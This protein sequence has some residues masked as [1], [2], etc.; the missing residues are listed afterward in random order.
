MIRPAYML[1]LLEK[2]DV[3]FFTGVPDSLLKHFCSEI[4]QNSSKRKHIIATN[5]GSA[6]GLATGHYIATKELALVY[7]QNSGLGNTINPLTS[8]CHPK[9][10]GIPMLLLI[11][12]RGEV[13]K[14]K[15][16]GGEDDEPQHRK[17]GEI[18]LKQL[19]LLDIPYIVLDKEEKGLEKKLAKLKNLSI[20]NSCPVA[21]V[22]RKNTFDISSIKIRKKNVDKRLLSRENILNIIVNSL[23]VNIP[24]ICTTGMA[25]RE[26]YEIRNSHKDNHDRDLLIIGG[27][28]HANQISAG[29][30]ISHP[31]K[32]IVCI[33]G[34]GSI[35]MHL[36]SLSITA[37][38]KN[39]IH[40]IINN[41]SHDS[42]GGQV[43]QMKN[44]NLTDIAKSLGYMHVEK[45]SNKK[46]IESKIKKF[47]SVKNKSIFLEIKSL[48]GSRKNLG[49]PDISPKKNKL[50][51]MKFLEKNGRF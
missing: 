32:K 25:S 1:A 13:N 28:G 20:K 30:A 47:L 43:T 7:M 39:I 36:G 21:I 12:W 33:D 42:V 11:G 18:T 50:D 37:E 5:E 8:I 6:I 4:T 34:D 3:S 44:L 46:Q 10:W 41:C 17:Q 22:V 15:K 48:K 45:A 16:R 23:P 29:I 26:L 14:T 51:V 9:I 40:I 27:M 2:L 19:E 31:Q 35:L 24:I 49:R 38:C